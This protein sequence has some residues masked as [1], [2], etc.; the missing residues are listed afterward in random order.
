MTRAKKTLDQARDFVREHTQGAAAEDF[1]RIFDRDAPEAFEV[2]ARDHRGDE[3]S[4][5]FDR[6]LY[7]IKIFFQGLSSK[8]S[9]A[10]RILFFLGLAL[11]AW[12]LLDAV[13]GGN[14][15]PVPPR[16]A[17]VAAVMVFFFL[18]TME[19]VSRVLVRDELEVA[20]ALQ[21][22]LLPSRSPDL[23]EYRFAH[24]YR[25]ANEVGGDYY[26]FLPL[27]DG[28]LALVVG[29]ASGH[30]MAAGLLMAIANA[31]LKT[32]LDLDPEPGKALAVL[33][34][35]LART[36]DNRAFMTLFYAILEPSFP[37]LR[38]K[39]GRIEELG[40]GALPLGIRTSLDARG[41]STTLDPGDLLVLYSDGLVEAVNKEGE[42]FGFERLRNLLTADAS[43][44]VIHDR[45]L[46]DFDG[47]VGGED[48]H[49]DLTLVVIRREDDSPAT[50]PPPTA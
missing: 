30:G 2:L 46:A 3:P 12:G 26:D 18:F 19:L 25:T 13:G 6:F 33:N 15:M 38:R 39:D 1:R 22:G 14:G 5:D 23:K 10:R 48:V 11:L 4:D 42:D 44:Q 40:S 28:R 7:R 16:L 43:P 49:D 50:P 27:P 21:Q 37:Y 47:F 36:G 35:T 41:D 29:D 24:S 9:P 20:K 32:A 31:T 34:R 8:L 17:L 45:V